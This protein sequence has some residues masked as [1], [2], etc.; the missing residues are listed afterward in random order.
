MARRPI[1]LP[2]VAA[3]DVGWRW[4][5]SRWSEN[6]QGKRKY[7]EKTYHSATLPTTNLTW[8]DLVSNPGRCC[9]K[10]ATNRLTPIDI[11]LSGH[12]MKHDYAVIA[13]SWQ[14]FK[15]RRHVTAYSRECR[16]EHFLLTW[17]GRR[18]FRNPIVPTWSPLSDHFIARAMWKSRVSWKLNSTE[19][20]LY[21]TRD[22][23]TQSLHANFFS[24]LKV[25][26][27]VYA[28]QS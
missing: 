19:H 9:A 3:P 12:L 21:S 2:T 14:D 22:H 13:I 7:W 4:M 15:R 8:P 16:K 6:W 28:L 11:F 20:T 23:T 1:I 25:Y 5:C 27:H 18:P 24:A 10:Q 26:T 17:N